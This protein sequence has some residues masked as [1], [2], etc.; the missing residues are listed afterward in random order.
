MIRNHDICKSNNSKSSNASLQTVQKLH[1]LS[2]FVSDE[3]SSLLLSPTSSSTIIDKLYHILPVQYQIS[4]QYSNIHNQTS[5]SSSNRQLSDSTISTIET[6]SSTIYNYPISTIKRILEKNKELFITLTDVIKQDVNDE[7]C[8]KT[9]SEM[10]VLYVDS[11]LH[12]LIQLISYVIDDLLFLDV[13]LYKCPNLKSVLKHNEVYNKFILYNNDNQKWYCISCLLFSK[14][15]MVYGEEYLA[16]TISSHKNMKCHKESMKK[17]KALLANIQNNQTL[18]INNDH[19]L[20]TNNK[21]LW[22]FFFT[23]IFN[24]VCVCLSSIHSIYGDTTILSSP[25]CG[26]FLKLLILTAKNDNLF[27][28][29]LEEN[30]CIYQSIRST[31]RWI[32]IISKNLFSVL[33]SKIGSRIFSITTDGTSCQN[34][35]EMVITVR[36]CDES[37]AIHQ[38]FLCIIEETSPS[39][40]KIAENIKSCL[41][42]KELEINNLCSVS[43]DNC[44]C[45]TSTT[46]GIVPG[47]KLDSGA[48]IG[49]GCRAHLLNLALLDLQNSI[50]DSIKYISL[51]NDITVSW[52]RCSRLRV[53][54][55]NNNFSL[56]TLPQVSQT[57]FVARYFSILPYVAHPKQ[58]LCKVFLLYFYSYNKK[59][60]CYS[61]A[62]SMLKVLGEISF[63]IY[64]ECWFR[65][66]SVINRASL[67]LQSDTLT[68]KDSTVLCNL[69][70]HCLQN[71][72]ASNF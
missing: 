56:Y 3:F 46:Y 67:L 26:V 9:V 17:F 45:N 24:C 58:T 70:L 32:K 69:Q 71:T 72:L 4:G 41:N 22:K 1:C 64:L 65:I 49:Y 23:K 57:R 14:E 61:K 51:I 68:V 53:M 39:G 62:E 42:K 5:T 54:I 38:Y 36:V 30:R 10:W 40:I 52:S 34:L 28:Q 18:L 60:V 12:E 16:S 21:K 35:E 66:L 19:L 2:C 11:H 27:R 31:Q 44:I 6:P 63:H 25:H 47:L 20:S 33:K 13:E 59:N 55:K 7:I 37:F 29:F 8:M 48:I 43:F 50:T 15:P